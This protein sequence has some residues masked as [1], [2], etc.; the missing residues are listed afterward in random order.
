MVFLPLLVFV[1]ST[2]CTFGALLKK[3]KGSFRPTL[4]IALAN[5]KVYPNICFHKKVN[6]KI[7]FGQFVRSN[8]GPHNGHGNGERNG[9]IPKDSKFAL[10]RNSLSSS[11]QIWYCFRSKTRTNFLSVLAWSVVVR[12]KTWYQS[13]YS[14]CT[15]KTC[16]RF[17]DIPDIIGFSLQEKFL[18]CE[19]L[20]VTVK[21]EIPANK[22][23]EHCS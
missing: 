19:F 21:C 10:I 16:S 7:F 15:T 1:S 14:P 13:R 18:D 17:L 3:G 11:L 20:I 2:Y 5:T 12:Q 9:E 23:S 4:T 22:L 8:D 6:F